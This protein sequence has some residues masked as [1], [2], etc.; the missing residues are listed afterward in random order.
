[1]K[2]IGIL[3]FHKSLNY[4]AFMQMYSLF[5]RVKKDFP[6]CHVEVIDCCSNGIQRKYSFKASEYVFSPFS[7]FG[8]TS[9]VTIFKAT[10]K[11]AIHIF[12]DRTFLSKR[13]QMREAFNSALEYVNL[14]DKS[15]C[16][17]SMA[18]TTEYINSRY[19]A[20]IVGS[21]CVWEFNNY[22]FPNI[23]YLHDVKK[24]HKISY[25]ACAQGILYKNLTE[26][27]KKYMK[28]SWNALD[29]VGVRDKATENLVG[30]VDNTINYHHCCDPTVLLDMDSVYEI[31]HG[32]EKLKTRFR[33]MGID[34]SKPI[35]GLMGNEYVG[36]LCKECAG[37][38]YQIV[39]VYENS[40]YA[41]FFIN[42][43][44]PFEWAACFSLFSVVF[45]GKFH[46]TLLSLKNGTNVLSFDYF[47]KAGN[48]SDNGRTKLWDLYDRLGL[49]EGRYFIG[50]REYSASEL[51]KIREAFALA[52]STD[53][54]ALFK[55]RLEHEALSYDYFKTRLKE[56][57][58]I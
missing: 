8:R 36:K 10:V 31:C 57:L 7:E 23:Y 56:I 50:K 27:Q 24:P 5:M 44:T 9:L 1:M 6:E 47:A 52:M 26:Y 34:L 51:S 28:E 16:T 29:F 35:I 39:A 25:A 20:V 48:F 3:T 12:S 46:G 32:T 53:N 15:F 41:D 14:S 11:N 17:D 19:D 33:N 43:L 22:P 55:E 54:K 42:D 58:N 40:R 18:E 4:G 38:N 21:D 13:K 30:A 37:D 45:T 2:R 49:S